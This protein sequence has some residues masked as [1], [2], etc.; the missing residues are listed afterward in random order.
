MSRSS[1]GMSASRSTT[2]AS[3]AGVGM[4]KR[5]PFMWVACA[6]PSSAMLRRNGKTCSETISNIVAGSRFFSRDQ[7]MSS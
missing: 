5:A 2:L 1:I 7:R 3:S 6:V 4:V